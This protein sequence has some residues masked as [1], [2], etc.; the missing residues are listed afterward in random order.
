MTAPY[1]RGPRSSSLLSPVLCHSPAA[2]PQAPYPRAWISLGWICR[3][4][5][6]C[7]RQS[8]HADGTRT[9]DWVSPTGRKVMR[10]SMQGMESIGGL[11]WRWT[12]GT[13][14]ARYRD[15]PAQSALQPE[16]AQKHKG[17]LRRAHVRT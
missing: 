3:H 1:K 6:P 15:Q 12:R 8:T 5:M 11:L 10:R 4:A 13:C 16:E 17:T 7:L 2:G 14:P 9:H